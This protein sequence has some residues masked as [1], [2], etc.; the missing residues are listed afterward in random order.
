MIANR[1][2]R[3]GFGVYL[4]EAPLRDGKVHVLP[5]RAFLDS[6]NAGDVLG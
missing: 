6:L 5:L 1:F 2:V 4:G 3:R